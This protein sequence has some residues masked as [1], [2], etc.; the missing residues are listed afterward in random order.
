MPNL[1]G[2]H[3]RESQSIAVADSWIVDT[4]A[5]SENPPT[6]NYN[7]N[8]HWI[9][10]VN[11]GYGSTGTLP[12]PD[13][14]GE[15]KDRLAAYVVGSRGCSR[16]I[17]GNEPN[18]SREWPDRQPIFP[19]QY[20]ACYKLCRDAIHAL[21]GHEKDE[22]LIA[23]PGPWNAELKYPGNINGDWIAYFGDVIEICDGKIDG[24]SLHAYTHGYNVS[25]VTSSA[26][27]DSPFQNRH[28]EFRTYRDY[29]EAI[30]NFLNHLPCYITEANGN[31]PW[32]VVGL[33][34]AMANEIDNWN[35]IGK[36]KI[37]ALVFY[38]YPKYDQYFI[39][40]REDV[41]KEYK[42]T[43]GHQSPSGQTGGSTVFLPDVSS[44][45]SQPGQPPALPERKIDPR[46][47][48]RGVS[49]EAAAVAPG[50]PFWFVKEVRWYNEQEADQ[51][52]PDH[53]LMVDVV[54]EQDQRLVGI[55]L[56][57]TWPTGS[58]GIVTEEKPGEPYSANYP[59]PAS[60]NEFNIHVNGMI[61]SEMVKGI[62]MGM[63]TPS[64]F[65]NGIHTTTGVVFQRVV[66][67]AATEPVPV[68]LPSTLW[69]R[70]LAAN[71]RGGPG[72]EFDI[73]KELPQG[74]SLVVIGATAT[75]DWTQVRHADKTGWV[76][77]ALLSTQPV[78]VPAPVPQPVPPPQPPQGDNWT[79]VLAWLE[80]WEGEYQNIPNDRG[81]W[82]GC[83]VGV[84][85]NKGTKFGISACSYPDLDIINL[86]KW[87]AHEIFRRDFWIKSGA[88]KLAWPL[89]LLVMD[90]AVLHGVGTAQIWLSE[91]GPNP[92]IFVA[93][94]LRSY[95]KAE[96]WE[97]WDEAW[98]LRVCELLE[99]MAK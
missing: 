13:R 70:V 35:K 96:N 19:S 36:P 81:N 30:P 29:L 31:G 67:P 38:R 73:L 62:G 6:V 11:W 12:T 42:A 46:A 76:N 1:I 51:L 39:E 65:N 82:T 89:C 85:I 72:T 44:G 53:H 88:N 20:A 34:P 56:T 93:K 58:H 99:Q 16:W 86:L 5:L 63:D 45:P 18:L 78:A 60:R 27:M 71:L 75:R 9:C 84:G 43:T 91:V 79:R 17:I 54:G 57:V 8:L 55:Q 41:I 59:M 83:K 33:I 94:R 52:G 23:A 7:V 15:Y 14:Y 24:F 69:V 74:T 80:R 21:S 10:R 64:G 48:S 32:Q 47:V 61:P 25:L 66:M 26:R 40:G 98:I 37:Q 49:I 95:L 92:Y 22:V 68:P 2:L 97:F 90:T 3:D 50:K 77:T 28:F 87:Q 4:I